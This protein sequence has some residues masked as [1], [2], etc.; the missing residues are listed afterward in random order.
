MSFMS[1]DNTAE[2]NRN[3]NIIETIQQIWKKILVKIGIAYKLE[4]LLK[5]IISKCK[6][7][8]L[9][10]RQLL[11]AVINKTNSVAKLTDLSFHAKCIHR[12]LSTVKDLDQIRMKCLFIQIFVPI[13]SLG[14]WQQY[15][16]LCQD[17]RN[18]FF[19][20]FFN[21]YLWCYL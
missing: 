2:V 21:L 3:T 8:S 10:L 14:P 18:M 20:S 7:I 1:T 6:P 15:P 5:Y 12:V 13:E 11:T 9:A 16:R 17:G 19:L 4:K